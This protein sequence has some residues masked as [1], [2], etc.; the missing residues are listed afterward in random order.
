M[1]NHFI[2]LKDDPT[3]KYQKTLHKI[4]NQS[5]H[6]IHKTKIKTLMLHKP[7]APRL[8]VRIKTHKDQYPVRPVVSNINTPT[9]RTATFFNRKILELIQ[10]PNTYNVH[11]S[12]QVANNLIKFK[13]NECHKCITL[14]IKDLFTNVPIT[15]YK[16]HK[17]KT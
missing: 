1:D 10:L 16:H 5:D 11:N 17:T 13:F 15:N 14:D 9:Y 8:Q 4:L 2:E 12:I 6:I 7:T 3:D